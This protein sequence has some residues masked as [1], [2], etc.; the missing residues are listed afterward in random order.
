MT[1]GI[2][3]EKHLKALLRLPRYPLALIEEDP[4][5]TWIEQRGGLRAVHEYLNTC[6]L[7]Q[8]E[9]ELLTIILNHPGAPVQFYCDKLCISRRTYAN[10]LNDLCTTLLLHLNA[11]AESPAVAAETAFSTNNVPVPLTAM[12]GADETVAALLSLLRQ[13]TV[14][15]I[16]LTGPGGVGKTRLALEVGNAMQTEFHDGVYFLSLDTIADTALLSATIIRVLNVHIKG[17]ISPLEALKTHLRN[18][19]LLLILDNLEHLPGVSTLIAGL[20]QAAPRLRILNTSRETLN[21]YGEYI[22]AVMP[23]PV[24]AARVP[25]DLESLRRNP[26]VQLFVE[27]ARAVRRDFALTPSNAATIVNICRLLDGLPMA[28]ELAAACLRTSSPERLLLQLQKNL[29]TLHLT[30]CNLPPRHQSLWSIMEW[31]YQLLQPQHQ[32]LFRQLAVFDHSWNSEAAQVICECGEV[33]AGLEALAEKSLIQASVVETE[34]RFS[35]LNTLREYAFAQLRLAG[36]DEATARRHASYYLT[37]AEIADTTIGTPEHRQWALWSQVEHGNLQ[38]ALRWFLEHGEPVLALRLV[39]AIWRFWQISGVLTEGRY[40]LTRALEAGA[41]VAGVPRLK[42]LWGAGWLASSQADIPAAAAYFETGI[43]LAQQWQEPLWIALLQ[44]G[45]GDAYRARQHYA[46]ARRLFEASLERFEALGIEDEIAWTLDHLSRLELEMGN[47]EAAQR[48]AEASLTRFQTLNH[49]WGIA[50]VLDHLADALRYQGQYEAA[51]GFIQEAVQ[52]LQVF[53]SRWRI[54]WVLYKLT[55]IRLAQGELQLARKALTESLRLHVEADNTQ[56]IVACLGRL[57]M[58]AAAA[59]HFEAAVRFCA[60]A[61]TLNER[62]GF[63][64][65]IPSFTHKLAQVLTDA[66]AQLEP[67]DFT[68]AWQQGQKLTFAQ[69]LQRAEKWLAEFT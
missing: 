63:P 62:L 15:C 29:S 2:W 61:Q 67:Q 57:A 43:A 8:H 26:A 20:L 66:R 65:F 51:A 40:W 41:Q 44:V 11:V 23:L 64:P 46:E 16:T 69:A 39:G 9:Q 53:S 18:K 25:T 48:F 49:Q 3:D 37:Q 28:L 32:A 60:A 33:L 36:E 30:A 7:P 5:H 6:V 54:A 17:A 59:Q 21:I 35:M 24:P 42:A 38:T 31:S 34:T 45:L 14:R 19:Q 10:Y 22:F 13:P 12:I 68:A 50:W 56:G 58:L 27:R 4:W 47:F 55:S 1:Q 52:Y